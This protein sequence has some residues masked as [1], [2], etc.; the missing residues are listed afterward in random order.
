VEKPPFE[1]TEQGWGE[2]EVGIKIYFHSSGAPG[3]TRRRTYRG[4]V[5]R[6]ALNRFLAIGSVV[7]I[8]EDVARNLLSVVVNE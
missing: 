8:I 1:V 6:A 3:H 5:L 7:R 4:H 2:F